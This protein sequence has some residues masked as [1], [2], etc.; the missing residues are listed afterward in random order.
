MNRGVRRVC[1]FILA[2][3]AVFLAVV[4]A[5]RADG[6]YIP[7]R[8]F[9][10]LPTI[11][12]QRAVIVYRNGTE[13]LL[14]ESAFQSDSPNVAWILPLPAP[15]TDLKLAEAGAISST[16]YSMRPQITHDLHG[17]DTVPVV[18]CVAMIPVALIMVFTRDPSTRR[19]NVKAILAFAFFLLLLSAILLPSLG[20]AG[21]SAS[22]IGE[23]GI[24][25]LS[26]QR[27]GDADFTV[28][29]ADTPADLDAWLASQ[30]M[31]PLDDRA[32]PLVADY[33]ARHWCFVVGH[34]VNP[35]PE[36]AVPRPLMATFPAT[37]AVFPMKL[38]A[39]ANTTTHVELCVFAEQ[40]VTA[41]G[42]HCALADTFQLDPNN[43]NFTSPYLIPRAIA[44]HT[45]AA[46]GH[47][48]IMKLL[49]SGCVGTKLTAD[50]PP[51]D[52]RQDIALQTQPVF[53]HRDHFFTSLARRQIS[54]AIFATGLFGI[55][56][57]AS[58]A[59]R[60]RRQPSPF[61]KNLLVRSAVL[62]V[63]VTAI[64]WLALPTTAVQIAPRKRYYWYMDAIRETVRMYPNLVHPN[65]TAAEL[66]DL[67]RLLAAKCTY[68]ADAFVNPFT[69]QPIRVE[70]SPGNFTVQTVD[71]VTYICTYNENGIGLPLEV[72]SQN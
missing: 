4:P 1:L 54:I 12:V 33:I 21:G 22:A 7:D 40:Q 25:I 68:R 56:I 36:L 27:L 11:P 52:M 19:A 42:F 67:P 46:L 71:G 39:L 49:W 8:A 63:V 55:L 57:M 6:V 66:N 30:G 38:T 41:K 44:D 62:L 37:Q 58:V 64:T 51:E 13:T 48:D 53:A 16:A 5:A 26:M 24:S 10:A 3:A 50:M 9:P 65:M 29:K 23:T 17:L 14:V 31:R 60:G 43:P 72:R 70:A 34:I 2:L 20:T 18:L 47:P 59:L 61:Q 69:G 35:K 32:Q 15:P 28:L 45:H